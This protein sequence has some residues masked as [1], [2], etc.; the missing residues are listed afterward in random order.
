MI[1]A[2]INN[3]IGALV[4]VLYML[5][6]VILGF[7]VH[8]WGHAYASVK[9]GDPGPRIAGRLSLNPMRHIDWLGLSLF[10][11]LG[12]GWAKP[13]QTNPYL[14]NNRRAGRIIV[15]FA[16][17]FMNLILCFVFG[18]LFALVRGL[19]SSIISQICLYGVTVNASL[20]ALNLLPI[21]PLDGSKILSA[22]F[23]GKLD[24]WMK[25]ERY[26]FIIL[27]LLSFTGILSAYISF[28]SGFL[29]A[30]AFSLWNFLI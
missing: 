27:L 20:F 26:G 3:P 6:G 7:T 19:A 12:F 25:I 11:L 1:S 28:V 4:S 21:P 8:E 16:G 5:P 30:G 14:Y 22:L 15:S 9:M 2:F 18:L 10:V 13:V 29:S 24:I 17:V 23:P